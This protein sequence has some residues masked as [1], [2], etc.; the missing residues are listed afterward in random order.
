MKSYQQIIAI[1]EACEWTH[2]EYI[3]S[4]GLCKGKHKNSRVQYDSGH[5]DLP[6]YLGDRNAMHKAITTKFVTI[7]LQQKFAH[8]LGMLIKN[9]EPY[10]SRNWS[11]W[12][13]ITASLSQLS[14][15][16]LRTLGLW[17]PTPTQLQ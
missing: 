8:Q 2:C 15:A 9:A 6:D 12:D 4:L 14:E 11:D 3:E 5:S 10:A 13:L 7:E 17:Q 16:L 1:A